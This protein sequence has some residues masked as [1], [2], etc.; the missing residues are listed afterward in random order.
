M[1]TLL[2]L[3]L[4]VQIAFGLISTPFT[5]L[6][7]TKPSLSI[8]YHGTSTN[9]RDISKL[10]SSRVSET[11]VV[12]PPSTNFQYLKKL[13]ARVKRLSDGESDFLL[14]FWSDA[15]KCFQIYP[16]MSTT[17]VSVTTT[18]MAISA[19]L[20][21]PLHWERSCRWDEIPGGS[22]GLIGTNITSEYISD[23]LYIN[24]C[25]WHLFVYTTQHYC[26]RYVFTSHENNK[27]EAYNAY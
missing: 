10:S 21:N 25:F 8:K 2:C 20:A 14:S 4:F 3:T 6:R 1:R 12:N 13:D 27:M 26:I 17:R 23:L 19:I 9:K 7:S 16:N 15:L 5:Q 18:C 22:D 11:V 24:S